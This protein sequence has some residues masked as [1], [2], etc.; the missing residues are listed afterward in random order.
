[1]TTLLLAQSFSATHQ[2]R[3]GGEIEA[4][5][6]HDFR[7]EVEVASA[8]ERDAAML[9]PALARALAPLERTHLEQVERSQEGC[10]SAERIAAHLYQALAAELTEDPALRV[11]SVTVEEAPG[12]RARFERRGVPA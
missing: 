12:C 6:G 4:V 1:V 11:V 2:I 10:A 7:C 3:I 8:D 9:A 5:H